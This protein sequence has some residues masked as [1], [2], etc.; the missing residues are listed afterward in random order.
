[1][2]VGELICELKKYFQLLPVMFVSGSGGEEHVRLILL[3]DL[4]ISKV[5]LAPH[6]ERGLLA[7][8]LASRLNKLGFAFSGSEVFFLTQARE[9]AKI[10]RVGVSDEN[11]YVILSGEN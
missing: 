2:T 7:G 10:H 4:R 9:S 5:F 11:E 3:D 8:E 6:G 1:M